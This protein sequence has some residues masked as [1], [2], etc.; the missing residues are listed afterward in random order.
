M[1]ELSVALHRSVENDD[2]VGSG[3]AMLLCAQPHRIADEVVLGA[4]GGILVEQSQPDRP[5]IDRRLGLLE[6]ERR[7]A[8]EEDCGVWCHHLALKHQRQPSLSSHG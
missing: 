6:V 2:G 5:V 4:G 1:K 7:E 8:I 3:V